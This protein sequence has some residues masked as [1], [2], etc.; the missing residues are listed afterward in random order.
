[1]MQPLYADPRRLEQ[2]FGDLLAGYVTT[3]VS[4]ELAQGFGRLTVHQ[5]IQALGRLNDWLRCRGL[6]VAELTAHRLEAFI[7]TRRRRKG[8]GRVGADVLRRFLQHLQSAGIAPP[9]RARR[10]PSAHEHLL[11]DFAGYL[12]HQR[13][14]SPWTITRYRFWVRGFLTE[15]FGSRPP[16]VTQLR[17]PDVSAY[18]IATADQ[19]GRERARDLVSALRAFLRWLQTRGEIDGALAAAVP[20]VATWRLRDL[21]PVLTPAEVRR[22]L[23]T[24]NR[25]TAM[26]RRDYAILLLLARL[27]LRAGEVVLLRL[28]DVDWRGGTLRVRRKGG[29]VDE[30]PMPPDVGKALATYV[31]QGRPRCLERRVFLPVVAPH[32]GFRHSSTVSSIV[33]A[34]LHRA[35]LAPVRRGAHL[36]R[37]ALASSLLRR[38]APMR[39]ISQLLGHREPTSTEVYARVDIASLQTVAQPWPGGGQ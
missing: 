34:A 21:P 2:R 8:S 19:H 33:A 12:T 1:M 22:V 10:E 26:G 30:L 32:R 14:L 11:N 6:R 29:H 28:E 37:H 27:G 39:E 9:A 31:Q 15:Q 17:P 23:R 38:G 24:C 13:G 20:T 16:R 25:R 3:F 35:G 7:R 4:D 18:V 5:H 36:L